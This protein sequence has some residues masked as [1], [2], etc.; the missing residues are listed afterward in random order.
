[1]LPRPELVMVRP[2]TPTMDS[3]PPRPDFLYPNLA[4]QLTTSHF[5]AFHRHGR[6]LR[7]LIRSEQV[8]KQVR[9]LAFVHHYYRRCLCR[10][11]MR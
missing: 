2:T 5:M 10:W 8:R 9:F 1:M 3:L 11:Y 4:K 7:L 6:H